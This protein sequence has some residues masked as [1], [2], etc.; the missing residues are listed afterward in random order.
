LAIS[1]TGIPGTTLTGILFLNPL[2]GQSSSLS[3]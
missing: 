3:L 2:F 1:T